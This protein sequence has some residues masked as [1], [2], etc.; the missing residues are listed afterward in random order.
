MDEG[1]W[2][3]AVRKRGRK[4]SDCV[5]NGAG[6]GREEG[7]REASDAGWGRIFRFFG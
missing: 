6:A 5:E 7:R 1:P 4:I 2:G 3:E